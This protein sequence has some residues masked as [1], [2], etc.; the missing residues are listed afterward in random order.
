M[1]DQAGRAWC[2]QQVKL[3]LRPPPQGED[4]NSVSPHS[5]GLP[6]SIQDM[7]WIQ[8]L[9]SSPNSRAGCVGPQ[10]LGVWLVSPGA[11]SS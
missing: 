5:L 11:T 7:G 10:P 3:R 6:L 9:S 4:L 8:K 1:G 2:L